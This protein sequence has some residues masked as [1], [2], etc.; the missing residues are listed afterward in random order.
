MTELKRLLL[1]RR[2]SRYVRDAA[3]RELVHRARVCGPSWTV[4]AVGVALPGLRRVA[5]KLACGY[6]GDT[7]DLDAEVLTGFLT[8]LRSIDTERPKIALR[9]CWIAYRAGAKLR[10]AT[11][12]PPHAS[13]WPVTSTAP[14]RPW[15]H[16]DLVLARGHREGHHRRGGGPDRP[17]P[18]GRHTADQRRE[19]TRSAVSR[20]TDATLPRRTPP[21]RGD[22]RGKPR[23]FCVT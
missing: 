22:S 18:P 21:R 17:D 3:W 6:T 1:D 7:A 12:D 15:G 23:N 8:A 16:P 11:N 2:T 20:G 4:A 10:H 14:P 9:L 13:S 19:E 5:G